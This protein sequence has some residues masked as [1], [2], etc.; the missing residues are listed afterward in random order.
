MSAVY[1]DNIVYAE[2]REA[3]HWFKEEVQKQFRITDLRKLKQDIAAW[4]KKRK[5]RREAIMS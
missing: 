1:V 3:R 5:T 2:S 4:Y